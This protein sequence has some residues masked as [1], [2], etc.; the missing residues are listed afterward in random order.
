M[1]KPSVYVTRRVPPRVLD[2]LATT[3]DLTYHDSVEP[4]ERVE[5]LHRARDMDGLVT[6]RSDRVDAEL[7]DAVGPRL[8]VIANYAVGFDNV[9]LEAATARNVLVSNTPDV[10]THATAEFAIA[11]ML[12]LLRRVAEGD[13]FLRRRERWVWSPTMMVGSSLQNRLLGIV[14]LGRIGREVARLATALGARVSYADLV[15]VE[16]KEYEQLALG[17]LLERSEIVSL[18]CPLV[19][20]THHLISTAEFQTMQRGA[21]LINTARGPIVDESALIAALRDGSIA[22]AA[23]DV[24]EREPEVPDELLGFENVVLAPHLASATNDTREAMGALCVRA[25][26]AVLL[27]QVAPGNALNADGVVLGR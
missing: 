26:S 11:L 2:E 13:R 9:D 12:S 24:Y 14:G 25:L 20:D 8:R 5:L 7:L 18:H 4:P 15:P 19:P 21:Y 6:T 23:L 27:H 17:E 10:L 22:G 3:F 16:S 1:S